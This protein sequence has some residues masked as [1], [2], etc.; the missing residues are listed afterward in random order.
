MYYSAQRGPLA[1]LIPPY[2]LDRLASLG[3]GSMIFRG[4]YDHPRPVRMHLVEFAENSVDFQHFA[5]LHG[6]M[7]IPWTPWCVPFMTVH[8]SPSWAPD[9]TRAHIAYFSDDAVLEFHG[10]KL[11]ASSARASITFLGPGGLTV[12]RIGIPKLGEVLLFHTHLPL[13][14]MEQTVQFRWYADRRMPR[15]IVSYVVGSW[16]AQWRNDLSIWENKCFKRKPMLVSGDGPVLRMR[17][18]YRQFYPTDPRDPFRDPAEA[19]ATVI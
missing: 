14:P 5:P 1:P 9:E 18:W 8:H 16:I 10:R 12:F 19:L 3:D 2:E 15:A 13:A 11:P 17:E 4:A 6:R 7:H